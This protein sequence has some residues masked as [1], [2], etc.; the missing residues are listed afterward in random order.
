LRPNTPSPMYQDIRRPPSPPGFPGRSRVFI[1]FWYVVNATLFR[2]SPHPLYIWRRWLLRLFGA[3]IGKGVKL[4]PSAQVTYPWNVELGDHAYIGDEVVLY[5]LGKIRIGTFTSVSYR[6]FLCTGTH[7][8]KDPRY[9]L[10]IKP[11]VIE[12]EVWLGA[13]CFIGPGVSIG[14]GAVV[15]ACSAVF[16][17]IPSL[18]VQVGVPARSIGN[19]LEPGICPDP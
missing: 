18:D 12:D 3:K 9:P 13:S 11:V 4:R 1:Q 16:K 6:A 17:D 5:S 2:L 19:R 7:D 14:T 10:V 15:G 8:Y